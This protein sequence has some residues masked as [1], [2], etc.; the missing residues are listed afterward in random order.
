MCYKI[1]D[2]ALKVQNITA[3][4]KWILVYLASRADEKGICWP[5]H[6]TIAK[7]CC[8]KDRGNVGRNI[9]QLVRAG[10]IEKQSKAGTRTTQ[11]YLKPPGTDVGLTYT[12]TPKKTEI[13]NDD[14]SVIPTS[15]CRSNLHD[16]VGQS[17]TNKSVEQATEQASKDI[18]NARE[19]N[20]KKTNVVVMPPKAKKPTKQRPSKKAQTLITQDDMLLDFPDLE[21][22][23]A[24]D[25]LTV[26]KSKRAPLTPTAW[27]NIKK[28]IQSAGCG[29]EA[30]LEMC[31]NRN[32]VGFKA[33]WYWN[34]KQQEQNNT[35]Y[36]TKEQ[37][38]RE[39]NERWKSVTYGDRRNDW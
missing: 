11:Y 13:K 24:H 8:F 34:A 39:E 10:L 21:L 23:T 35:Q 32:W 27:K 36:Q 1:M 38:E 7:D 16:D 3:A 26:R 4:Q 17:Y 18:K 29:A 37:R 28:E 15:Q 12:K 25:W 33:L 14:M 5:S 20:P 19:Q 2:R 31:V 22:Q 30:A 9:N 6:A